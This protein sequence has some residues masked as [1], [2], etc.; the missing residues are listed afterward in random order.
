MNSINEFI[1]EAKISIKKESIRINALHKKI[2]EY[3]TLLCVIGQTATAEQ[4]TYYKNKINQCYYKIDLALENIK[5]SRD[6]IAII[7]TVDKIIKS[8]GEKSA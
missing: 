6:R 5:S 1:K 4:T 8:R 7:K 3:E 2:D